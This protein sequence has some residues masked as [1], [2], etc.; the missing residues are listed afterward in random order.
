MGVWES[1][2]Q[3]LP[4]GLMSSQRGGERRV[5]GTTLHVL[6]ATNKSGSR[7]S[8]DMLCW[9]HVACGTCLLTPQNN[10]PGHMVLLLSSFYREGGGPERLPHLSKGTQSQGWNPRAYIVFTVLGFK[11]AHTRNP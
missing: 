5:N 10:S 1:P 6:V 9:C 2:L 7:V 4:Q 3:P 11:G 8:A